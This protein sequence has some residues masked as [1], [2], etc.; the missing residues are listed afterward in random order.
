VSL[1]IAAG[2]SI[3][4]VGG[5]GAG[6]STL[7]RILLAM[8]KPDSGRV[9]FNDTPVVPGPASSLRWYRRAVQYIPQHPVASLDPGMNVE[10]LL[11]E[12]L[13]QL[14]IDG[15][16]RRMI[17]DA[18]QRVDLDPGMLTRR[19]RELSGGQNQRVAIARALVPSPSILLADEPV[20]GLDLPLRNTVLDLMD[21]LVH[22]D[23]L[24]LLFVSHDLAAVARLC[25][26]TLILAE[27]SVVEQGPTAAV[28]TTTVPGGR[29]AR[30][31]HP[32]A[33]QVQRR[34]Q[35]Q[36]MN[37]NPRAEPTPRLLLASQ[38]IFNL[39]F[40]SVVPFLAVSM[41][42][43]FGMGAMAVGIV[44]GARTFAQQG[45]FLMGGAAADRWG[46]R[47][48][49]IA[50][51]LSRIVG[52][53]ILLWASDFP[54]FLLGAVVTGVGGALF[55][56]ALE[57][58]VGGAEERRAALQPRKTTLFALLVIFGEIGAV[59][60]PLLGS[61]LLQTGFET[62]L[63]VGAG[64]FAA[65]AV[66]FNAFLPATKASAVKACAGHPAAA[67]P[68]GAWSCLKEKRFVAFAAFY[69]VNLFAYNQLYFGLPVELERSDA[70][71]GA[72]SAV[73][74]YASMVTITLQ[75][76]IA[77]LMKRKGPG[78][79]LTAGFALQ[80]LGFVAIAAMAA[81]PPPAAFPA[82][83][84]FLLVTALALGHMCVAPV[85]M[86]LVLDFAS[87]RPTGAYYG[88][89]ASCGGTMVLLGNVVLAPLYEEAGAPSAA[90]ASP[91]L[92]S[93]VFAATSAALIRRF[94]PVRVP[95]P[96]PQQLHPA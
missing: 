7:L 56:P 26:R 5:S 96:R 23:G 29:G 77:R 54:L 89:L 62:A 60:G 94:L 65:M 8:E 85:A 90:A 39:G 37:G 46:P 17:L 6:K 40:Y 66:V 9:T 48:V 14:R 81:V 86:D 73:F 12:P 61:I 70:G 59:A 22:R 32:A 45:L 20:S 95:A 91:W 69:S 64:V 42:E 28:Y 63:L 38:L 92:V 82:L 4:L 21:Q 71:R 52:Y 10:R 49:M 93:A 41:R 30:H 44:L 76:P 31:L 53:L 68:S 43:D 58:L 33:E 15:D 1:R 83:P 75:W 3:G 47:P 24:G 13:R 19:P 36:S 50:G 88:L 74:A 11:L 72:L 78:I 87:G 55:S 84:A 51:C 79:A 16:H 25:S 35:G 80:A 2:D 27:G 34:R 18:L 67:P 57:S